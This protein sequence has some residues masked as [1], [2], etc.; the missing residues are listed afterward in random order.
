MGVGW[1]FCC[2]MTYCTLIELLEEAL[3]WG[4]LCYGRDISKGFAGWKAFV[5]IARLDSIASCV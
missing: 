4:L 5:T 2:A 1:S 3:A